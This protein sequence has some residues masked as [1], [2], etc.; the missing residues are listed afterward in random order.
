MGGF[1]VSHLPLPPG[2]I[3]GIGREKFGYKSTSLIGTYA[4]Q[5]GL[6]AT[7]GATN[8]REVV[9]SGGNLP[10]DQPTALRTQ[11]ASA[12][13]G[14]IEGA[15]GGGEGWVSGARVNIPV[16]ALRVRA[17]HLMSDVIGGDTQLERMMAGESLQ[18]EKIRDVY[19]GR[20]DLDMWLKSQYGT[21]K[22]KRIMDRLEH[23]K[24]AENY[25]N[26]YVASDPF[27]AA[28]RG[29]I[30]RLRVSKR[31]QAY[32]SKGELALF[33][34][35]GL[36][37]RGTRD[38][39]LDTMVMMRLEEIAPHGQGIT[40]SLSNLKIHDE[41]VREIRR[42]AQTDLGWYKHW[43]SRLNLGKESIWQGTGHLDKAHDPT[44]FR[45]WLR[46]QMGTVTGQLLEM[47]AAGKALPSLPYSQ[48][49]GLRS[50]L[51]TAQT[52]SREGNLVKTLAQD[53]STEAAKL[54]ASRL[55]PLAKSGKIAAAQ[56]ALESYFQAPVTKA[57]T[58]IDA[59]MKTAIGV[60]TTFGE[61]R[62]VPRT[63][64][65]AAMQVR[66]LRG[67]LSDAFEG[68][69]YRGQASQHGLIA[70]VLSAAMPSFVQSTRTYADLAMSSEKKSSE[71]GF[72]RHVQAIIGEANLLEH[73]GPEGTAE[74]SQEALDARLAE[75]Q[76][77]LRNAR[78]AEG[79]LGGNPLSRQAEAIINEGAIFDR[80]RNMERKAADFFNTTGGRVALFG[81]L[82]VGAFALIKGMYGSEEYA[83][84]PMAPQHGGS[85]MPPPPL[86]DRPSDT[87]PRSLPVMANRSPAKIS[88][89]HPSP[90]PR[91]SMSR[92]YAGVPSLQMSNIGANRGSL[93]IQDHMDPISRHTV[94]RR[95]REVGRS[96]FTR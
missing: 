33:T 50:F 21:G 55:D 47:G 28:G 63:E 29:G 31:V 61:A 38:L 43:G 57:G 40:G 35:P 89:T 25:L 41:A 44:V 92:T 69:P 10:F 71:W 75:E 5:L 17:S 30:A 67:L 65:A 87:G 60:A 24:Y 56:Q 4:R 96:D 2:D 84:P 80:F 76:R 95:M 3:S 36:L 27:H 78:T 52:A 42:G 72:R 7:Y 64:E 8:L 49:R 83:P 18:A 58:F 73:F 20:G 86:L 6:V 34:D 45:Q 48:L 90:L 59:V 37:Y 66:E 32:A 79:V 16:G 94:E 22:Y 85:P 82:T 93:N 23:S 13:E 39:D 11:L 77:R 26:V 88:P 19:M 54:A 53:M 51:Q 70:Q 1:S 62:A 74:A 15:R 46:G 12:V 14:I 68:L 9:G 91:H 81:G